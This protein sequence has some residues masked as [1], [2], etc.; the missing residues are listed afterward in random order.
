LTD[1]NA[2]E[3]LL[4]TAHAYERQGDADLARR[5]YRRIYFYA[6]ASQAALDAEKFLSVNGVN[7]TPG[8]AEED[9]TRANKLYEANRYSEAVGAYGVA[10]SMFPN[11]ADA[12]SR[13]ARATR[14]PK[15]CSTPRSRKR[16]SV[17]GTPRVRR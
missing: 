9:F 13:P 4:L 7:M 12:Q 11:A 8:N 17:S 15:H 1:A 3:A 5:A 6:P 10:L 14:A 16:D 2:P